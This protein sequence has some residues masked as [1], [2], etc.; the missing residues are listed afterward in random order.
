MEWGMILCKQVSWKL[1]VA[2]LIGKELKV[3]ETVI[4]GI[5]AIHVS[6]FERTEMIIL[7]TI[8][9]I[10]NTLEEKWLLLIRKIRNSYR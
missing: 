8:G 3:W 7:L 4:I 9:L 10:K 1:L 2:E 6:H 5:A